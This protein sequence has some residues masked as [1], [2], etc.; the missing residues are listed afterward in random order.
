MERL[1]ADWDVRTL[2]PQEANLFYVP[3]FTF[4]YTHN[5]GAEGRRRRPPP[6]QPARLRAPSVCWLGPVRFPEFA[7]CFGRPLSAHHQALRRGTC[8]A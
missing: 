1:L 7:S 6:A 5:G 2:D 3:A 8:S 4:P